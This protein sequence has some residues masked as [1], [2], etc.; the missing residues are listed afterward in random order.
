MRRKVVYRWMFDLQP[1]RE[2]RLQR[3][4]N[5]GGFQPRILGIL[6]FG[7]ACSPTCT[8]NMLLTYIET[9]CPIQFGDDS[10]A[11]EASKYVYVLHLTGK[12]AF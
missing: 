9:K 1:P 10:R 4:A 8:Y 7:S 2:P 12:R 3:G 6:S 11:D 5:R